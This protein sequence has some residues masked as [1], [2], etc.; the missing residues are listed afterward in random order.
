M[1]APAQPPEV[2]LDIA[3][4]Q[5]KRRH[6]RDVMEIERRV[7]P[8]PWSVGLFFGE[9]AQRPTRTYLVAVRRKEIV[10]Y[11]GLMRILDE[12]HI[13]TLAVCPE[14]QRRAVGS[15]LLLALVEDARRHEVLSLGLEVRLANWPAQRLYSLFGFR[16]VGIRKNYYAETGE[17]ALVMLIDDIQG[18]EFTK[19]IGRIRS[20]LGMVS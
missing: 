12:G 15:R 17:D 9:L 11:G 20:R 10:G 1:R 6:V 2:P 7:Y 5:M 16:P 8:R 18:D 3:I 4:Q 13:T 19:R 14:R